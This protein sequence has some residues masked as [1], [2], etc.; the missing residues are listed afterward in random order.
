V[1]LDDE[2]GTRPRGAK[3]GLFG[4]GKEFREDAQGDGDDDDEDGLEGQDG[5]GDEQDGDDQGEAEETGQ[6]LELAQ[7][8]PDSDHDPLTGEG[9][10]PAAGAEGGAA[11]GAADGEEDWRPFTFRS[12]GRLLEV[13]GA[14]EAKDGLYIPAE[15]VEAVREAIQRGVHHDSTFQQTMAEK[16][17][18]IAALDP[19]L[20]E[21]V[22]EAEAI[23]EFFE[24]HMAS[25]DSVQEL[26]ANFPHHKAVLAAQLEARREK[27]A[28]LLAEKVGPGAVAGSGGELPPEKFN[29]LATKAFW[30][31]FDDLLDRGEFRG[32][33]TG[34]NR[35]ALE[36]HLAR[37]IASYVIV[38]P[39]D[40]PSEGIKKGEKGINL[41]G[42][43]EEIRRFAE[44]TGRTR[45]VNKEIDT[46]RKFN[47]AATRRP[48][49]A[50]AAT[51][52]GEPGKGRRASE[53]RNREEWLK[54]LSRSVRSIASGQE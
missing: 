52:N 39:D 13:E 19:E 31:H 6:K 26:V 8:Q 3:A 37:H 14:V 17:R 15:K 32:L 42:M 35:K 16:D 50:P 33:F 18:Q 44:L 23:L 4:Q 11:A 43:A 22:V 54:D 41:A 1:A 5:A 10:E 38:A 21:R 2:E 45:K 7:E 49:K 29:E 48:G 46:A 27:A 34:D 40:I 12:G 20:N 9:S 51:R 25:A 47:R 30:G 53:P 24:R 36:Q 28:R